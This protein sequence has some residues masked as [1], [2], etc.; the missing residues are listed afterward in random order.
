MPV[1]LIDWKECFEIDTFTDLSYLPIGPNPRK[2]PDTL[3]KRFNSQ[4]N[5]TKQIM[6][7]KNR[8]NE[9]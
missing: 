5:R 2:Y 3:V 4:F 7:I 9:K 6:R 1:S 8:F